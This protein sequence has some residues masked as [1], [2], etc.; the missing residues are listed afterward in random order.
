MPHEKEDKMCHEKR[1]NMCLMRKGECGMRRG[2][3]R[4]LCTVKLK[5]VE[6]GKHERHHKVWHHGM[7]ENLCK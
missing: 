6:G 4:A 2:K 5:F 7:E 3:A 1:V